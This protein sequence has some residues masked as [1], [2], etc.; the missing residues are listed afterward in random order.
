MTETCLRR[1]PL[2]HELPERDIHW[3]AADHGVL[4]VSS[5]SPTLPIK[6][7]KIF[8]LLNRPI[9]PRSYITISLEENTRIPS[10]RQIQFSNHIVSYTEQSSI[11][12]LFTHHYL[13]IIDK[14]ALPPDFRPQFVKCEQLCGAQKKAQCK[15]LW[16]FG[17]RTYDAR[18]KSTIFRNR[19]FFA[20]SSSY[21]NRYRPVRLFSS[22]ANTACSPGAAPSLLRTQRPFSPAFRGWP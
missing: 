20:M 7:P 3:A 8:I 13:S 17:F 10:I 4:A 16:D 6:P 11:C 12:F 19:R 1:A 21:R 5:S 14:P 22:V 15:T 9:H 18:L 2:L